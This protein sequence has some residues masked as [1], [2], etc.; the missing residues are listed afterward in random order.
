MDSR[1]PQM[2]GL[3]RPC[4]QYTC[5]GSKENGWRMDATR[6]SISPMNGHRLSILN[7]S[8]VPGTFAVHIVCVSSEHCWLN[9]MSTLSVST[10]TATALNLKIQMPV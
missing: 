8:L 3:T 6:N 2:G 5:K 7:T 9:R 4:V 10:T 1:N